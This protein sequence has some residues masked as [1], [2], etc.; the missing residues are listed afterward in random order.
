MGFRLI[1]GH[2]W[3]Y[4]PMI[5]IF[6]AI[7]SGI[8]PSLY[9]SGFPVVQIMKGAVRFGKKNLLTK[10]FLVLQLILAC[11]FI[12]CSVMFSKNT[13]F[14]AHRSWGYNERQTM[15]VS[16]PDGAAYDKMLGSACA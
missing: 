9:I 12:T 8:Y 5:M 13:D 7:A 14:L 4:L 1:D 6:T 2:L 11:I 10:I 16:V 15:Y 3:I